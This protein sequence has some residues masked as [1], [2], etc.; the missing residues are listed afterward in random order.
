M[1]HHAD[2]QSSPDVGGTCGQIA[3]LLHI[4][5]GKF[6]FQLIVQPVD[7][8]P[9]R[10]E[11]QPAL[12]D[13]EAQ[14]IFFVHH[15]TESLV[16]IEDHGPRALGFAELMADQLSFHQ[17]LAIEIPKF[18]DVDV[19]GVGGKRKGIKCTVDGRGDIGSI[20]GRALSNEWEISQVASE[21]NATA[22]HDVRLGPVTSHPFATLL[23][24]V[25]EFH[26]DWFFV[27]AESQKGIGV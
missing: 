25:F 19:L 16:G 27:S 15:N 20:F 22:N 7:A 14:V 10:V 24:Q 17:E 13:L 26:V 3:I 18:G 1:K 8:F 6:A 9:S 5:V 12:H 21:P 11:I 4:G 2:S 23:C